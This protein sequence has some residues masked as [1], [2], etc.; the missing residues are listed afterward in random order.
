MTVTDLDDDAAAA[1]L[2]RRARVAARA[3]A[4]DDDAAYLAS[5]MR[6]TMAQARAAVLASLEGNRPS[7]DPT[8]TAQVVATIARLGTQA[9]PDAGHRESA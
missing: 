8:E 4:L 7:F 6:L 1:A 2:A 5:L 3:A 9:P